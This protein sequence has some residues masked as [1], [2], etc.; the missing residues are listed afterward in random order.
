MFIFRESLKVMPTSNEVLDRIK[1][2]ISKRI[3]AGLYKLTMNR[4]SKCCVWKILALITKSNDG[5]VIKGF[6]CCTKCAMV[7]KNDCKQSSMA[8]LYRHGCIVDY[9]DELKSGKLKANDEAMDKQE[10]VSMGKQQGDNII[11]PVWQIFELTLTADKHMLDAL[12]TCRQCRK[13]LKCDYNIANKLPDP[14]THKCL[15]VTEG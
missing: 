1:W 6:V 13:V 9:E 14:Q 10:E 7:M 8:N 12:I 2:E 11:I 4:Y 15:A 3:D 5:S